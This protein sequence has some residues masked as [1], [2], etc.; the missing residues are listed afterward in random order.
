M[1]LK[2]KRS[3]FLAH[4]ILASGVAAQPKAASLDILYNKISKSDRKLNVIIYPVMSF[5]KCNRPKTTSFLSAVVSSLCYIS[6]PKL[7]SIYQA[8]IKLIIQ[9]EAY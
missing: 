7:I 2:L 8:V 1:P 9:L 3:R 4:I 5:D 6:L